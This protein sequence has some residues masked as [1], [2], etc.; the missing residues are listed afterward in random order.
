MLYK[1]NIPHF[2]KVPTNFKCAFYFWPS[3]TA[4][5]LFVHLSSFPTLLMHNWEC[6]DNT[7][8]SIIFHCLGSDR[9]KTTEWSVASLLPW[10]LKCPYNFIIA[11]IQCSYFCSSAIFPALPE[12][13][14]FCALNFKFGGGK[15]I[16][17]H[18]FGTC[19]T[20]QTGWNWEFTECPKQVSRPWV[21]RPLWECEVWSKA[22]GLNS[23]SRL[24][25]GMW[26]QRTCTDM[27]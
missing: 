13:C 22:F 17:V 18:G 5:I 12:I 1:V 14:L 21:G 26:L 10:A 4:I 19:N 25:A 9:H 3:R 20:S 11:I 23:Y 27:V 8:I 24:T 6:C 16:I 2:F 15:F 7:S